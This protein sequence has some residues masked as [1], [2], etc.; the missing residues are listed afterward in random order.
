M[1]LDGPSFFVQHTEG[2]LV[3]EFLQDVAAAQLPHW[4][5][6]ACL[7]L[8]RWRASTQRD[9]AVRFDPLGDYLLADPETRR[10]HVPFAGRG[11][12]RDDLAYLQ[13]SDPLVNRGRFVTNT[14]RAQVAN[15]RDI[16]ISPWLIHGL[17]GTDRELR[18]TLDF[19]TRAKNH[20]QSENRTLLMGL[21]ATAAVFAD[22]SSRDEMID[23]IVEADLDI[24]LYLRMTIELPDSRKPYG[25]A[26]PLLGLRAA[27][28]A[29]H[30]N[31]LDVV[32]PQIGLCGWLFLPFG[33]Q[34][35]GAG[36]RSSMDR[37][38]RPVAGG[39]GGGG[40]PPLHWYFSPDLL[41]PVL[42]EELPG[43]QA[44]GVTACVCPYCTATPP[45]GGTA[46]NPRAADLHYLW[47][48]GAVA[49]EVS[50]SG[51]PAAAVRDRVEAARQLWQRVRAAR[52]PL[53]HRSSE[54]HLAAWSA[55]VA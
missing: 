50:A 3:E 44:E 34:S 33:V 43:L 30:A 53:D 55:A 11:R 10:L 2:D 36:A 48:C 24:P 6:G 16:L 5:V 52:V 26:N 9:Y 8:P 40:A 32:L 15:G 18:A 45:R 37:N 13:E 1:P 49:A 31:G 14:L 23:E 22:T 46:F 28:D 17:S 29:L 38:L 42:A 27:V 35:F 12:A 4:R 47:W 19:A 51:D 54:T 21:E 20:S 39:R 7:L 25:T 41:G